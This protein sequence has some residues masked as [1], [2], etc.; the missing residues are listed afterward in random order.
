ML[1]LG[2]R[3]ILVTASPPVGDDPASIK[4][5][6]AEM[7]EAESESVDPSAPDFNFS[8]SSQVDPMLTDSW[9]ESVFWSAEDGSGL[10]GSRQMLSPG[11]GGGGGGGG[12]ADL[13][14]S[15][16]HFAL[17]GSTLDIIRKFCPELLPKILCR[18]TVFARMSPDQK[19]KVNILELAIRARTRLGFKQLQTARKLNETAR[20]LNETARNLKETARNLN[21]TARNPNETA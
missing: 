6:L 5:S 11:G 3:V 20:N 2:E 15:K 18:G 14:E 4:Y 17:S 19:T 8:D 9:P 21:E 1:P 12:G 10:H 16:M 7:Y 13:T